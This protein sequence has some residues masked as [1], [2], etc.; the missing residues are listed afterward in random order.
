VGAHARRSP[1]ETSETSDCVTR[2]FVCVWPDDSALAYL[3]Q[4]ADLL[5]D[6]LRATPPTR[7]HLT[8][9]FLGDADPVAVAERLGSATLTRC[10]LS[11]GS[12]PIR[13]GRNLLAAAVTGAEALAAAVEAAVAP[14]RAQPAEQRPFLGHITIGRQARKHARLPSLTTAGP[15]MTVDRVALIDSQ[16]TNN[17][18]IYTTLG[19]YATVELTSDGER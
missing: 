15:V 1:V 7:W 11:I 2:L 3:G 14:A 6:R 18:P 5:G 8:L 12:H 16:L 13:V 4:L 17:G 19:E 10:E 9:A